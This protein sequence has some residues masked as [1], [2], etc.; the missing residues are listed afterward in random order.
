ML[1]AVAISLTREPPDKSY[2]SIDHVCVFFGWWSLRT[3][4]H[5]NKEDNEQ[6]IITTSDF[7]NML[8]AV[9]ISLNR[10]PPDKNYTP[11]DRVCVFVGWWRMGGGGWGGG[12]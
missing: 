8:F 9:A 11:I 6:T 5:T 12:R 10:E 1:L 4:K 7:H 2:T 3:R